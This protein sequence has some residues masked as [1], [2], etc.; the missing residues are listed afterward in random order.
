MYFLYGKYMT[1]ELTSKGRLASGRG[2]GRAGNF[3]RLMTALA[4]PWQVRSVPDALAG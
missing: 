1:G 3:S 4:G 2:A